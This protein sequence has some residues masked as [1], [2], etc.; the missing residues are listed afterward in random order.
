MELKQPKK[1]WPWIIFGG[2][3]LLIVLAA[4]VAVSLGTN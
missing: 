1:F 2:F 3:G 4:I